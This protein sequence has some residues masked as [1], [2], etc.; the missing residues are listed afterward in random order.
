VQL[1]PL[2]G[3]STGNSIAP[4]GPYVTLYLTSGGQC[5]AEYWNGTAWGSVLLGD[6]A[7]GLTGGLSV[8]RSTNLAFARR[9]DGQVVVFYYQ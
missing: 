9:A 1:D 8:Q 7:F 6:G 5:A 2:A 3:M 4:Y